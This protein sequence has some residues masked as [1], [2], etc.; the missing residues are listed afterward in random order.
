MPR[1]A[2]WT[3]RAAC[4]RSTRAVSRKSSAPRPAMRP[5]ATVVTTAPAIWT[6]VR[7][8]PS[9]IA[10]AAALSE[11]PV[12]AL[13]PAAAS[14]AVSQPARPCCVVDV[15]LRPIEAESRL[16]H[17]DCCRDTKLLSPCCHF[18]VAMYRGIAS[19]TAP[20]G[21]QEDQQRERAS[22]AH[23]GS[24][25]RFLVQR[26]C[27][28]PFRGGCVHARSP[29]SGNTHA[30]RR[31]FAFAAELM[32]VALF[33]PAQPAIGACGRKR[34][35]ARRG[36]P[37]T[38]RS[39][40]AAPHVLTSGRPEPRGSS[41][42]TRAASATAS[43]TATATSCHRP[44]EGRGAPWGAEAWGASWSPFGSAGQDRSPESPAPQRARPVA[45]VPGAGR[46]RDRPRSRSA[47]LGKADDS[48]G[49]S[50]RPGGCWRLHTVPAPPRSRGVFCRRSRGWGRGTSFAVGA[51][52]VAANPVCPCVCWVSRSSAARLCAPVSLR[53]PTS[54]RRS[55]RR[56]PPRRTC[57][58]TSRRPPSALA[59]S[60]V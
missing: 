57:T 22:G 59:D 9:S 46:R 5:A 33:D 50:A 30:H 39:A 26:T 11:T 10:A 28:R 47:F 34:C 25:S 58:L 45:L 43:I 4:V 24:F 38:R 48:A 41:A 49:G 56:R 27:P 2:A 31:R 40:S 18:G 44:P 19:A 55:A 60:R 6:S 17:G 14:N 12:V 23:R 37:D 42:Q 53:R 16:S 51:F 36:P 15:A 29:A 8:P 1:S 21:C 20:D 32:A 54:L 3:F 13:T 52:D 35:V 7:V